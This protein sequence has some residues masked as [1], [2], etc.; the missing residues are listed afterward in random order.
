MLSKQTVLE[1]VKEDSSHDSIDH[2]RDDQEY[3]YHEEEISHMTSWSRG[4]ERAI[5]R[6]FKSHTGKRPHGQVSPSP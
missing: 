2:V 4:I 1:S 6:R 5:F 3:S